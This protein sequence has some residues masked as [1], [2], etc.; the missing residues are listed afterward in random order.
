MKT[1]KT[2]DVLHCEKCG[3]EVTVTKACT[4][5]DCG[6]VCCGQP[7]TQ[8]KETPKAGGCSCCG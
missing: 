5:D 8:M 7:M 2:G 1:A 3:A 4:C 6:I